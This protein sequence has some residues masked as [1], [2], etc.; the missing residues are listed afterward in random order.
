M[1]RKTG[2]RSVMERIIF[3]EKPETDSGLFSAVAA[4]VVID[5][6]VVLLLLFY[7][8]LAKFLVILIL[9]VDILIIGV[10][11]SFI[12]FREVRLTNKRIL[13]RFGIYRSSIPISNIRSFSVEDPRS[14]TTWTPGVS[15]WRSR[16]VYCFKSTSPFVMIERDTK[17]L[18]RVYFNVND[19]P[20][21]IAR[22]GKL[23]GPQ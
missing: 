9:S 23:K 12:Q 4:I 17:K 7:L 16:V 1:S 3:K 20:N 10:I 22:L 21:F 11:Y 18:R 5:N 19:L 2:E 15:G 13:V 14:W 6:F 8:D